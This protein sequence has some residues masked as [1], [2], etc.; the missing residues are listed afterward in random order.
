MA[1]I[2]ILES[3]SFIESAEKTAKGC[4]SKNIHSVAHS[5]SFCDFVGANVN[6]LKNHQKEKHETMCSSCENDI[7][8]K[9]I[10]TNQTFKCKGCRQFVANL[11]KSAIVIKNSS[12]EIIRNSFA[13]I[14]CDFASSQAYD[15]L[16]HRESEH[17]KPCD[18]C[19]YIAT[20]SKLLEY[21][22]RK[23]H[24]RY[25][26][27]HCDYT[28]NLA[29]SLKT[30]INSKHEGIR[31]PCDLCDFTATRP[32][33]LQIHI[34]NMHNRIRYPCDLC[35]YTATRP[36]DLKPHIDSKHKGIRYPCDLCDFTATQPGYLRTH[37]ESKHEGIRYP[38]DLCDYTFTAKRSLKRHE[39]LKHK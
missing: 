22:K 16:N 12:E 34:K 39:K 21:H 20:T 26:C 15:L 9:N 33:N 19:K 30:H 35:D 7:Y 3:F 8:I 31:Y 25:S 10:L 2:Y 13:C 5:C 28:T 1:R 37:K 11:K 18:Q 29:G 17:R 23:K 4:S 32:G 27:D 6:D 36:K 14:E 38:C 24:I